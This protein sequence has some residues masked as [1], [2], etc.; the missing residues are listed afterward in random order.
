M[1]AIITGATKGIGKAIALKLAAAGYNLAVCSRNQNEL[2]QLVGELQQIN[3]TIRLAGLETDCSNKVELQRF[4]NFVQQHFGKV[5]VL[6]NNAGMFIPASVLDE[7]DE[8]LSLQ[9]NLNLLAPHFLCRFFGK[10]MKK[11]QSG[12]IINIGSVAAIKPFPGAGSYSVTKYA[13]LGLT[14]VLRQE[15]MNHNVK[16]T[17]ILPGSTLTESWGGIELPAYR[18]VQPEDVA[19]AVLGC[20]QMSYGC[21]V[22]EILIRPVKGEVT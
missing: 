18:F 3:H 4:A 9:L 12:H 13:L 16:V 6:I 14:N 5:D 1:N 8:T 10:E 17:S 15:L 21:N 11:N 2:D 20:L 22:D 19:S 7:D